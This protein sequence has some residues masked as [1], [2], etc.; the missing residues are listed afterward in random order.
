MFGPFTEAELTVRAHKKESPSGDWLA[1]ET[2]NKQKDG[3]PGSLAELNLLCD[4]GSFAWNRLFL[5]Q[6]L[7]TRVAWQVVRRRRFE[8]KY[9]RLVAFLPGTYIKVD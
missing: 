6:M 5:G 1:Q 3:P 7:S 2:I 8:D 9:S 4:D